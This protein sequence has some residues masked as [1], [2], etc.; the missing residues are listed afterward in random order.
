MSAV[1][2][3]VTRAEEGNIQESSTD[4][5]DYGSNAGNNTNIADVPQVKVEDGKLRKI[6]F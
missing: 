5:V 6:L 1:R 4:P 2:F 3:K